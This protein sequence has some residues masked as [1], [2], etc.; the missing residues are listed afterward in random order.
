MSKKYIVTLSDDEQ[1]ALNRLTHKGRVAAR[2][3]TRAHILQMAHNQYIDE[4]IAKALKISIATIERVR[5]KFVVGGLDFALQEEP[6]SG[7]SRKLNGKQEAFLIALACTTPP[8]GHTCWTMQLLAEKFI[9][10]QVPENEVSDETVRRILKKTISNLGCEVSG[11]F[12]P[13]AQNLSGAWKTFLTST[14]SR[15]IRAFQWFASTNV[16]INLLR[17]RA[18]PFPSS[19]VRQC[20]MIM[21]ISGRALAICSLTFSR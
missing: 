11:A 1:G 21:N 16:L 7:A 12:Q 13:S 18:D 19:Q 20:A 2:R 8:T 15:I 4:E 3:L 17:K 5:E 10:S 9:E 6:R 14:P